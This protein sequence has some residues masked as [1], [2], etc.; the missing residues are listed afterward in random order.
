MD[1]N[2]S[3]CLFQYTLSVL[4]EAYYQNYTQEYDRFS[5]DW[6]AK[7][8]FNNAIHHFQNIMAN[9]SKC[10]NWLLISLASMASS[11]MISTQ[12]FFIYSS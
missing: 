8:S 9:L 2:L 11:T 5:L 4:H 7:Y 3:I 6:I 1:E 10:F 12:H